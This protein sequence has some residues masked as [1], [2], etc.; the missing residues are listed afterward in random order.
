VFNLNVFKQE[1]YEFDVFNLNVFKQEFYEFDVF[2]HE[3]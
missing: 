1:F 2:K 3:F